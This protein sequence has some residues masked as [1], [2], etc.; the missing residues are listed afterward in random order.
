[1]NEVTKAKERSSKAIQC[2]FAGVAGTSLITGGFVEFLSN[3]INGKWGIFL[4]ILSVMLI[5]LGSVIITSLVGTLLFKKT[6]LIELIK[7]QLIEIMT[8]NGFIQM[9]SKERLQQLK[10]QTNELL[11]SSEIAKDDTSLL[12]TVSK[13]IDPVLET[14]YFKDYSIDIYCR[15]KEEYVEKTVTRDM[16]IKPTDNTKAELKLE[17]LF[18]IA[19]EK[20]DLPE[21]EELISLS[22]LKINGEAEKKNVQFIDGCITNNGKELIKYR[23]TP[24]SSNTGIAKKMVLN[25]RGVNIKIVVKYKTPKDDIM[26]VHKLPAACQ[27]YTAALRYKEEE[28]TVQPASFGFLD[29]QIKG[30]CDI[31]MGAEQIKINFNDWILPGDGICFAFDFTKKN[32]KERY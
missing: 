13:C 15:V 12:N 26:L 14:Y 16:T 11:Y 8:T 9:L 23:L 3:S 2:M 21:G 30:K 17:D 24:A 31:E 7:H 20:I 18:S 10:I 25:K 6:G 27:H 29:S 32:R 22:E 19:L 4:G 5:T 1:M 28:C